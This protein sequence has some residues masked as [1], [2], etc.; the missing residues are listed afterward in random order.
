MPSQAPFT[1]PHLYSLF[2]LPQ[3]TGDPAV[4]ENRGNRAYFDARSA[5]KVYGWHPAPCNTMMASVCVIPQSAFP[6]MPPPVPPM[7]P[8]SPP[9]PPRAMDSKSCE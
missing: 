8:P 6:C 3:F 2:N 5:D 7:P 1:S 9:S 4:A